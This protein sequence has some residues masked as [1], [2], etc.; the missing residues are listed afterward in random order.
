[1]YFSS[2]YPIHS[3]PTVAS[4][5]IDGN[6]SLSAA[7]LGLFYERQFGERLLP[8]EI[9]D[10]LNEADVQQMDGHI[11]LSE[12]LEV[13][14]RAKRRD[15]SI[16]WQNVYRCVESLA[17][18]SSPR[19]PRQL[20]P[21]PPPS[22]GKKVTELTE[23]KV[24]YSWPKRA[25][26]KGNQAK[27]SRVVVGVPSV[28]GGRGGG[29][30][31]RLRS[32]NPNQHTISRDSYKW[33]VDHVRVAT[34]KKSSN[35]SSPDLLAHSVRPPL[36]RLAEIDAAL[37]LQAEDPTGIQSTD[38]LAATAQATALD[39][40]ET[41]GGA[42]DNASLAPASSV[43]G[44]TGDAV[45]ESKARGIINRGPK[46]AVLGTKIKIRPTADATRAATTKT[47]RRPN[48]AAQIFKAIKGR[49]PANPVLHNRRYP[50]TSDKQNGRWLTESK[51]AFSGKTKRP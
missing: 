43:T 6:H 21:P 49:S 27:S 51:A 4:I 10:M 20:M 37:A 46:L 11:Q 33:P 14:A 48:A 35:A 30:G 29:E 5:D 24:S 12:F 45:V 50:S 44:P 42:L 40:I 28:G 22:A 1:M 38:S 36:A 26:G 15:S 41:P 13:C 7:E 9:Q 17:S 39:T 34:V 16:K 19:S 18:S 25:G 23:S 3:R 31:A 47:T 32:Q 8:E 2:T